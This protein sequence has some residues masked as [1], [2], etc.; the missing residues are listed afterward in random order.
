MSISAPSA[1]R[2]GRAEGPTVIPGWSEGPD[3]RCAIAHRGI[4]RFRVRCFAS[5]RNDGLFC[6]GTLAQNILLHLA[7]IK[8]G[9]TVPQPCG[10]RVPI[11]IV[12]PREDVRPHSRCAMR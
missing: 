6:L 12:K 9:K 3:L 2:A 11:Q 1:T 10:S 7:A 8:N 5:P 4:S